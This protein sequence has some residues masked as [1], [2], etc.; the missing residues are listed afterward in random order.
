MFNNNRNDYAPR[1]AH[2]LRGLLD[3]AGVPATGA[4][5]PEPAEPTLF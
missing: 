2:V 3:E 5:E 4:V 1:S